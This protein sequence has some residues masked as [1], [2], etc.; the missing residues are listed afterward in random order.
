MKRNIE[1]G[2]DEKTDWVDVL[3]SQLK[4]WPFKV[5]IELILVNLQSIHFIFDRVHGLE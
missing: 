2:E 5:L 1:A 4:L 3:Q